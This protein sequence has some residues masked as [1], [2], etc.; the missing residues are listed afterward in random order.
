MTLGQGTTG[1]MGTA[2]YIFSWS[3]SAGL[4]DSTLAHPSATVIVTSSYVIKV[5]DSNG[6]T[7]KDTINLTPI[8]LPL[9]PDGP[10][11]V[12]A[13]N[14][15]AAIFVFDDI[16]AWGKNLQWSLSNTFASSS[17]ETPVLGY[18]VAPFS[19]TVPISN[20]DTVFMRSIDTATTCKSVVSTIILQN[21]ALPLQKNVYSPDTII[22]KDSLSQIIIPAS[23]A[24]VS[25]TLN[26]LDT[27]FL[28]AL[29]TGDTLKLF[30]PSID[31]ITS[32]DLYATDTLSFCSK[33]IYSGKYIPSDANLNIHIKADSVP[34]QA[35][36]PDT[37]YFSLNNTGSHTLHLLTVDMLVNTSG[38]SIGSTTYHNY[39]GTTVQS[40][41]AVRDSLTNLYQV[42][43]DSIPASK[44]YT[45]S[46]V[47]YPKCSLIPDTVPT[48]AGSVNYVTDT[49]ERIYVWVDTG[50]NVAINNAQNVTQ[51]SPYSLYLN[52]IYYPSFNRD[53]ISTAAFNAPRYSEAAHQ[54]GFFNG[55]ANIGDTITRRSYFNNDGS[56]IFKGAIKIQDSLLCD[57]MTIIQ[58]KLFFGSSDSIVLN[59]VALDSLIHSG[60]VYNLGANGHQVNLSSAVILQETMVVNACL[61]NSCTSVISVVWG[62]D[63]ASLCKSNIPYHYYYQTKNCNTPLLYISRILPVPNLRGTD[64]FWDST[65]TNSFTKWEFE[66]Q[67]YDTSSSTILND[68]YIDLRKHNV[69][70]Y[71][72]IS[73]FGIWRINRI[74][75]NI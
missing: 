55:C 73:G 41:A 6:C 18:V 11:Y 58:A 28:S 52:K 51:A 64:L 49:A 68:V 70:S 2:P 47:L 74:S 33:K 23:Q 22:A 37:V 75:K 10:P 63:T 65:C 40:N 25:Y 60:Y 3:P 15:S 34:V 20:I 16:A 66:I 50:E 46:I 29:G 62:C 5:T 71:S 45:F 35:C 59:T 61:G 21:Y 1:T 30:T 69:S 56:S 12:T 17:I 27:V 26:I 48:Q 13:C 72:M 19:V 38:F 14:D 32:I 7:A 44:T 53:R 24:G 8:T 4:S 31:T 39:I 67:N 57:A 36:I 54:Q 42:T 9:P 43:L